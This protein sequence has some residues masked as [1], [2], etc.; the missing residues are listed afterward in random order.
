MKV[1][2]PFLKE[3]LVP[4]WCCI[5]VGMISLSGAAR[6]VPSSVDDSRL[7]R[8]AGGISRLEAHLVHAK[9]DNLFFLIFFA[10]VFCASTTTAIVRHYYSSLC[11]LKPFDCCCAIYIP[12]DCCRKCHTWCVPPESLCRVVSEPNRKRLLSA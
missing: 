1:K 6:C 8:V 4:V 5:D 11:R 2:A 10:R 9:H 7:C 12:R 3:N